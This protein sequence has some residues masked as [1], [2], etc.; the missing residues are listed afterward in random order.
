MHSNKPRNFILH[1][2]KPAECSLT[3]RH[4]GHTRTNNGWL[5]QTC[6]SIAID[7]CFI[8]ESINVRDLPLSACHCLA[9]LPAK[10]CAFNSL[11]Q[12]NTY[13]RNIKWTSADLLPCYCYAIK[14]NSRITRSRFSHQPLQAKE[15]AWLNCKLITA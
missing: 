1:E 5:F 8:S 3:L 10:T 4:I 9:A 15:G 11:M 12:Q 14:T 2:T 13:Y 7:L 6:G